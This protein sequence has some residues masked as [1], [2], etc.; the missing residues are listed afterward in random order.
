MHDDKIFVITRAVT[1]VLAYLQLKNCIVV[2]GSS[3]T[4]KSSIIHH[5]ALNLY[6]HEGYEI[7]PLITSP[8]EIINR[9]DLNKKQVFVIDDICG[10]E[11]INIPTVHLWKDGLEKVERIFKLAKL[12][13]MN[14]HILK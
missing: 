8:S 3:G 2:T 12:M 9:R 6:K 4:G 13:K 7:I 10:K 11:T 14:V 5:V 1:H